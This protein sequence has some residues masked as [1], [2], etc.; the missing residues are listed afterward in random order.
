MDARVAWV[1]IRQVARRLIVFCAALLL[2]LPSFMMPMYAA[3][4][5]GKA[6]D[7]NVMLD[8]TG[9]RREENIE[10]AQDSG[11]PGVGGIYLNN[12]TG[13]IGYSSPYMDLGVDKIFSS[14]TAATQTE[15]PLWEGLTEL[16]H[17]ITTTVLLP[18][19]IIMATWRCLYVAV[20]VFIAHIDPLH[21]VFKDDGT[22]RSRYAK[23]ASSKSWYRTQGVVN[24]GSLDGF[25]EAPNQ[26]MYERT[27][28]M[29]S[30]HRAF[31]RTKHG[32]APAKA[33]WAHYWNSVAKRALLFEAKHMFIGLFIV[34]AIFVLIHILIWLA[35]IVIHVVGD[36]A[37]FE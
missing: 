12:K 7:V 10:D 33:D 22:V 5:N 1:F 32:K 18:I 21:M 4:I 25:V 30:T 16:L 9:H 29:Q 6:D 24:W 3:A 26:T 27:T 13:E 28:Q 17:G 37:L 11:T 34:M 23:D 19:G 14:E 15:S 8:D 31:G 2:V 36:V 20:F 35:A